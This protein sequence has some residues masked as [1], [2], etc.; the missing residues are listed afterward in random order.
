MTT[1]PK[2]RIEWNLNTI[3]MLVGFLIGILTWG[4]SIGIFIG[5]VNEI[6]ARFTRE[7][8]RID[9]RSEQRRLENGQRWRDHDQLH[10]DRAAENAAVD[11]KNDERIRGLET[12]AR[13]LENLTYRVTVLE[14]SGANLT[15]SVEELKS[16][17]NSQASDIRIIKEIVEQ[18]RE[19]QGLPRRPSRSN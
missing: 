14:Q 4:V 19:A 3:I 16:A 7:I 5:K 12:E 15:K 10:K 17:L 6:D 8:A 11:A 13:K 1:I 18:M 2:G 9:D